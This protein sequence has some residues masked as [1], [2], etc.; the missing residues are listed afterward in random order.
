MEEEEGAGKGGSSGSFCLPQPCA[1]FSS[2]RGKDRR[3]SRRSFLF[4][5]SEA[6]GVR[7]SGQASRSYEG[8]V[9]FSP[10]STLTH[11]FPSVALPLPAKPASTSTTK[12]AMKPFAPAATP[13]DAADA[14]AAAA[15]AI[16]SRL[17]SLGSA[18]ANPLSASLPAKPTFSIA[19]HPAKSS[20]LKNSLTMGEDDDVE[21]KPGMIKFEG[22]IDMSMGAGGDVAMEDDGDEEDDLDEDA[23]FSGKD[24][25]ARA[26]ARMAALE[27]AN[28]EEQEDV[29]MEDGVKE[30]DEEEDELDAFMNSVNAK[31]KKVDAADKVKIG[32]K[33]S[34]PI[35][36][37]EEVEEVEEED[38]EAKVGMSAQEILACVPPVLSSSF[39][40]LT[41]SPQP[42]RQEGQEGPRASSSQ[43]R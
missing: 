9:F 34:E 3:R 21:R 40:V 37:E 33:A 16:S 30:E 12:P 22:E 7:S 8:C 24:A 11:P 35:K 20:G 42:R 2:S 27:A 18:R 38:E 29:K 10:F 26:A 4:S 36:T 14:A 6:G 31:V 28:E 39:P 41:F 19:S 1:R 15:A 25:V 43:A 32:I 13:A 5:S 23:K 17:S